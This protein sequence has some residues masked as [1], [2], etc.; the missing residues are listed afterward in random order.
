MLIVPLRGI[1][2]AL[3]RLLAAELLLRRILLGLLILLRLLVLLVRG[4]LLVLLRLLLEPWL[5]QG[6]V[7]PRT[8]GGIVRDVVHSAIVTF[9]VGFPSLMVLN[10]LYYFNNS[11]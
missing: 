11:Y 5:A 4:L 9:Q 10:E 2:P 6:S 7:A 8:V 3:R 1:V